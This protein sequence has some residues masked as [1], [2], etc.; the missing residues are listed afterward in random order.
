MCPHRKH[1]VLIKKYLIFLCVYSVFSSFAVCVMTMVVRQQWKA[2]PSSRVWQSTE[3]EII[4]IN[5]IQCD[6]GYYIHGNKVGVPFCATVLVYN[7]KRN[8][9]REKIT[10]FFCA[11]QRILCTQQKQLHIYMYDFHFVRTPYSPFLRA[12]CVIRI[13]LFGFCCFSVSFVWPCWGLSLCVF[14][15]VGAESNKLQMPDDIQFYVREILLLRRLFRVYAMC[16]NVYFMADACNFI[17]AFKS[18]LY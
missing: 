1:V 10:F 16:A 3:N 5:T 11:Q 18:F 7:S 12:I 14:V 8:C 4:K 15:R 9:Q 13:F 2:E 17:S 6:T